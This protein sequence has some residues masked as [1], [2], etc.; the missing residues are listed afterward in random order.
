MI[1]GILGQTHLGLNSEKTAEKRSQVE[2]RK[3][4]KKNEWRAQMKEDR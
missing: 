4:E 1:L 3:K 2:E